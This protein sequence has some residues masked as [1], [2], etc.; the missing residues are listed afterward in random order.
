MQ[1]DQQWQFRPG[2]KHHNNPILLPHLEHQIHHLL[3]SHQIF[4]GHIPFKRVYKARIIMYWPNRFPQQ[5]LLPYL[6]T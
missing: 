4:Q 3:E 2:H 6:I 1:N 5:T